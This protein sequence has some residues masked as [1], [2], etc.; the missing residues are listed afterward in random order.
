MSLPRERE[1]KKKRTLGQSKDIGV[2]DTFLI[3]FFTVTTD[4]EE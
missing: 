2:R 4:D 3:G 1:K